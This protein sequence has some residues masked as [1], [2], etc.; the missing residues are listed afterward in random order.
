MPQIKNSTVGNRLMIIGNTEIREV[1]IRSG[2]KLSQ[3][4]NPTVALFDITEL[5]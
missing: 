4:I 3:K 1:K 2:M 5:D